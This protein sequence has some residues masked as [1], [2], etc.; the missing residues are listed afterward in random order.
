MS[1]W[2]PMISGVSTITVA[3]TTDPTIVSNP[4]DANAAVIEFV[5]T[6]TAPRVVW[7]PVTAAKTWVMWNNTTGG[8]IVVVAVQGASEGVNLSA[9]VAA[10]L[11][12]A[13]GQIGIAG[14]G[15]GAVPAVSSSIYYVPPYQ[16][17]T[18]GGSPV[19]LDV[20]ASAMWFTGGVGDAICHSPGTYGNQLA[21]WL[22]NDDPFWRSIQD[23]VY[24]NGRMLL[25][26]RTCKSAFWDQTNGWH[27]LTAPPLPSRGN[28]GLAYQWPMDLDLGGS[29]PELQTNNRATDLQFTGAQGTDYFTGWGRLFKNAPCAA[30]V[31]AHASRTGLTID[32]TG[33]LTIECST[34]ITALP[35]STQTLLYIYDSFH[36]DTYFAISV[37]TTGIFASAGLHSGTTV[38]TSQI[39]PVGYAPLGAPIRIT[40]TYNASTHVVA[41]QIEGT[42]AATVSAA[43][44]LPAMSGAMVANDAASGSTQFAGPVGGVRIWR[45]VRSSALLLSDASA[46]SR[47]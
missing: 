17:D 22:I 24:S 3:D 15:G 39:S 34:I 21:V 16:Y 40:A 12:Y 5:G 43:P 13:E 23:D 47:Y 19:L 18:S 44:V 29:T 4:D 45:N 31:S 1:P 7:I 27:D 38:S 41:L 25:P 46:W 2:I 8:Q 30:F 26:P 37:G 36:T 6:I 42:Q 11:Y 10:T 14:S 32:P 33:G 20:Q 35:G 28:A 9:G